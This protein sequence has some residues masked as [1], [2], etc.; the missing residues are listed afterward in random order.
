MTFR[1]EIL[2]ALSPEYELVLWCAGLLVA[3]IILGG[4]VLWLRKWMRSQVRR[5]TGFTAGGLEEMHRSGRISDEEFRALRRSALGLGPAGDEE[6]KSASRPQ[7]R[8]VDE[9]G[10]P[11]DPAPRARREEEQ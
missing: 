6:S 11:E 10:T 8:D 2:S 4:V 9:N 3:V 5:R 1:I 7:G